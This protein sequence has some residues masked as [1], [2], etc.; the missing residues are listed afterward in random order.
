[1]KHW[2]G[3]K[4]Y[5]EKGRED[6]KW[7]WCCDA[8]SVAFGWRWEGQ[9]GQPRRCVGETASAEGTANAKILS[10]GQRR[11]SHSW[12]ESREQ[13]RV[14]S[15]HEVRNFTGNLRTQVHC[16]DLS[17]TG[18]W[19][20]GW[21]EEWHDLPCV[22]VGSLCLLCGERLK[23]SMGRNDE[24]RQEIVAIIHGRD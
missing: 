7:S 23:G 14:Y 6:G 15:E 19:E 22:S 8:D 13:G 4:C 9:R 12:T 24:T 10:Q 11:R 1:M 2:E 16:Q 3:D 5:K 17:F 18:T 20:N 21:P